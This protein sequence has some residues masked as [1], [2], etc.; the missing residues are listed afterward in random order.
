MFHSTTEAQLLINASIGSEPNTSGSPT[1]GDSPEPERYENV[2]KG[3]TL[4]FNY[5]KP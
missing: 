2:P 3:K 4:P 1:N 5:V